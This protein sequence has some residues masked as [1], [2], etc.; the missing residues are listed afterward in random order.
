MKRK[1]KWKKTY[2]LVYD[3]SVP[4]HAV[5]V[6]KSI[7]KCGAVSIWIDLEMRGIY[8]VIHGQKGRKIGISDPSMDG[9][10]VKISVDE[11]AKG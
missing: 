11:N 10:E 6:D 3:D 8:D 7:I 5:S 9:M 4:Y 2:T 1:K